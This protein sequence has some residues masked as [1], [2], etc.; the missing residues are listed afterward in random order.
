MAADKDKLTWPAGTE[1]MERIDIE[2][3]NHVENCNVCVE[4]T[5]GGEGD[6]PCLCPE[7]ARLHTEFENAV[8][9]HEKAKGTPENS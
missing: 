3:S 8:E 7:E 5:C 4:Y 6:D 9:A 2:R 1:E